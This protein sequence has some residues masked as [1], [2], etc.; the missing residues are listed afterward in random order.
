MDAE[1]KLEE[2]LDLIED[3]IKAI[4]EESIGFHDSGDY[5]TAATKYTERARKAL[6][7]H[8]FKDLEN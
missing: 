3:W 2:T 7:A 4:F 5:S 1:K 6:V 8:I